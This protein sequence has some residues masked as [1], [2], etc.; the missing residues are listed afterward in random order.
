MRDDLAVDLDR[1][2]DR[3]A[4]LELRADRVVLGW[5]SFFVTV[6]GTWP[7]RS[8]PEGP[9][10]TSAVLP[11][12]MY[13]TVSP[14]D[15]GSE[16]A[17]A[18]GA[19]AA[20]VWVGCGFGRAVTVLCAVTVRVGAGWLAAAVL[21]PPAVLPEEPMTMP[22]ISAMKAVAPYFRADLPLPAGRLAGAGGKPPGG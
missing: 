2:R 9:Y 13:V 4:A 15:A 8:V 7:A 14:E 16:V 11:V 21:V 17:F 20:V 5:P 19:L 10:V 12:T 22:M 3:A 6:I 1:A 18:A